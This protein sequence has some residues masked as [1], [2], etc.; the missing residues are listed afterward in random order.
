MTAQDVANCLYYVHLQMPADE[1]TR[2]SWRSSEDGGASPLTIP[3][4]LLPEGARPLTPESLPNGFQQQGEEPVQASAPPSVPPKDVKSPQSGSPDQRLPSFGGREQAHGATPGQKEEIM[5]RT[6]AG[7]HMG[8]PARKPLGSQSNR[9]SMTASTESSND[10]TEIKRFDTQSSRERKFSSTRPLNT[11]LPP[12][13]PYISNAQPSPVSPLPMENLQS[14]SPSP[15]QR[16]ASSSQTSG[17]P[18]TLT[19]IR[20]NPSSGHQ[21]N[22]GQV[23]SRQVQGDGV[24]QGSQLLGTSPLKLSSFPAID[25][26]LETSG[27][28]KF[29]GLPFR[30]SHLLESGPE[31]AFAAFATADAEDQS[32]TRHGIGVFSRRV[33]MAYTQSLT[34]VITNGVKDVFQR[35]EQA[36]RARM[37]RHRTDSVASAAS[38][39][40]E[41]TRDGVDTV[42]TAGPPPQGMRPKGYTF[43]SP[44]DGK[45]EFVTSVTGRSLYC[46]HTPYESLF[47]DKSNPLMPDLD[48]QTLS[49][50]KFNLPSTELL[51]EHAK[52]SKEQL[53]KANFSK[54][55]RPVGIGADGASDD[56]TDSVSSPFHG[57]LGSERAGGGTS[58]RRAKMGKLIIYDDGLKM[59][60]LVV[61]ANVGQWWAVWEKNF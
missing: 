4:K 51:A 42:I 3:R 10:A 36:G 30:K 48:T 39:T 52:N 43:V 13:A 19:L 15:R 21:C 7:L 27:Y 40:S 16:S 20:R 5:E 61:A 11:S 45:C 50:L 33:A 60:D 44:W 17:T 41:T 9:A 54:L 1:P 56:A 49:E 23:S 28:A 14:R 18:F 29:R 58:G 35:I 55:L 57:N 8:M 46:H 37:G 26:S 2:D 59:L 12:S 53:R 24:E 34:T 31:A 38:N 32:Q 47:G 6:A 22:V 25:I